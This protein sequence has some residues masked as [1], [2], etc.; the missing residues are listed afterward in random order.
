MARTST[1]WRLPP[2]RELGCGSPATVWRRLTEW[3]TAGVF[4]QLHLGILDR[5]GERGRVDW[6]RASVDTISV[7]AKRGGPCGR[8]SSRSWQAWIQAAPGL[9]RR[10]A[11]VA[12]RGDRS[13]HQRHHPCSRRCLTM[14]LL[15]EAPRVVGAADRSR[16][17][18]T[19]A[20][21]ARPTAPI[22]D[23]GGSLHALPGVGSSRQRGLGGTGGRS[24]GLGPG[25]GSVVCV[26]AGGLRG[27]RL[28]PARAVG[29]VV[30]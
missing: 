12:R 8:K 24:S 27:G 30:T 20:T 4:D 18:P 21:T 3:A 13:Q 17:T 23:G 11:A 10:R 25:F 26:C 19:R 9:R 6:S 16:S 14:S 5:L 22:C 7:R 2:A 28:E 15:S 29:W 1:L